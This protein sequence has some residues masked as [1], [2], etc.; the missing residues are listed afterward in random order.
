MPDAQ[1]Q[2]SATTAPDHVIEPTTLQ[3]SAL[4]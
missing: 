4:R 2:P 1:Q 3:G